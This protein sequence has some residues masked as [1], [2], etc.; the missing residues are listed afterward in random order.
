MTDSSKRLI[1]SFVRRA[2]RISPRQQQG[3]DRSLLTYG[4]ILTDKPWDYADLFGR[5][6]EVVLEI[7]FGMGQS[8]LT[9]AMAQ[10]D[11]DFIG[12]EV[13]QAGI[14]RLAVDLEDHGVNNV[15]IAP[16]DAVDVLQQ[17]IASASLAGVQI[18]FP[19]PWPKAR[20]HKR[21]L[22]QP[23]FVGLLVDKLK[24]GG[25]LHLATDWGAYAAHMYSVLGGNA[26]LTN[27]APTS[28][29]VSR[30]ETRPMTKFEK[31]GLKL[32]HK[33]WDLQFINSNSG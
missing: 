6:R 13:H 20:H 18:F 17:G 4:L 19:D 5:R 3:L 21:R 11:I 16:Y 26:R 24:P 8:L 32:G 9:M 7:G 14:G 29:F 10:P 15:R 33:I 12:I 27:L 2:G 28:G 25:F 30:P 1:K 22:I 31:R 23:D